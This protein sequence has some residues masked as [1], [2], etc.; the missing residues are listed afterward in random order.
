MSKKPI[1]SVVVPVHNA[2]EF[3][4]ETIRSILSQTF[5][6]FELLLVDDKSTDSSVKTIESI[7]DK[8]IKLIK[9]KEN[10]GAAVARNT[11]I[12]RAQGRYI[13]FIDAD[14]LWSKDKLK[15]QLD[16][17]QKNDCAFSFTSYEFANANGNPNGKVVN[18]PET[19]TYKQA[20]K[21]TTIWTSTVMLDMSKLNK[22]QVYMPNVRRGQDTA[23]WWKILKVVG[24][25]YGLDYVL[26]IYRRPEHSLSS[27][28]IQALKRTWNLYRN[29][30][31]FGIIRSFYYFTLYCINAIKRRV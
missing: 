18:V 11:G 5:Q 17:M 14:D 10:S 24:K 8:R 2:E 1:I 7:D 25:A 19:I 15:K 23:T 20:L 26:S 27:N 3:I 30:E 16:F 31:K 29:V 28:K 9:L 22:E 4:D 6:D 21:N 12:K 13:C